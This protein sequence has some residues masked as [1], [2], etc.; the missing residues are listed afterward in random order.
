MDD[1]QITIS[2][3]ELITLI[4]TSKRVP[5]M[6]SFLDS[7]SRRLDGLY[8]IYTEVLERLRLLQHEVDSL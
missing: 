4:E 6:E 5:G 1:L 7:L 3:T 8:T 2:L